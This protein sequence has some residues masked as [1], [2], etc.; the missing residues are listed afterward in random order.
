MDGKE[1]GQEWQP[2]LQKDRILETFLTL[3]QTDTQTRDE[4]LMADR[5]QSMMEA[6][7][8]TCHRDETGTKIGGTTGNLI[9]R[10]PG[11]GKGRPLLLCAHMDRV[12]PGRGIKPVVQDGWV[13]SDGTTI[14][15]ADDAG[16]LT[17]IVEGIRHALEQGVERPDIE[18]VFTVAE[19]GGLYG[20]QHLDLSALTATECYILDSSTPVG[21]LIVQAPAQASIKIQVI[22]R[23][24][25]GGVAPE[26]GINALQVAAHALTQIRQGRI[27][28]ETTTNFGIARGG[29]ATN[30]VMERFEILGDA[31]SLD[32]AKLQA[33]CEHVE[34]EFRKAAAAFGAEVVVQIEQKYGAVNFTEADPIVQ[35]AMA[36]FRAAGIEPVLRATGGGS[37]A[38]MLNGR[39][40]VAL[41]H[42]CGY[43]NAHALTEKQS[44]EDLYKLVAYVVELIKL[45]A[46]L[47]A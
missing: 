32:L 21:S 13:Y 29:E 37:D 26:K 7:G 15:G 27:D 18:V 47:E 44:I 39:G 12:T 3:V 22:G 10:L 28:A 17:G 41:N 4:V 5:L 19:E 36:A 20:A 30:I 9:C 6:L 42:G 24:A 45:H 31:R 8:F 43:T 33:Q 23:A 34:A 40:L 25:H 35:R 14:L 11:T 1:Y 16:G 46:S 2:V 38:N